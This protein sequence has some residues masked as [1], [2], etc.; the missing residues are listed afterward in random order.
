MNSDRSGSSLKCFDELPGGKLGLFDIGPAASRAW[1][2]QWACRAVVD[3]GSLAGRVANT[4]AVASIVDTEVV[5]VD[6]AVHTAA[7]ANADWTETD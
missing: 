7:V 5:S 3:A 6:T 4:A 2:E 1:Q